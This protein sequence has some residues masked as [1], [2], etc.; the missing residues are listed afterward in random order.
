VVVAG[1]N[2]KVRG[3]GLG[4]CRS[5]NV[6][7]AGDRMTLGRYG[8]AALSGTEALALALALMLGD[9]FAWRF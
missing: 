9:Y 2:R 1:V 8:L 6:C 7:T 4:S 3:D 5:N